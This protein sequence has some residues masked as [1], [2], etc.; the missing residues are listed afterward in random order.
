[1]PIIELERG[2]N[3]IFNW[4]FHNFFIIIQFLASFLSQ[5]KDSARGENLFMLID[6]T[7][8]V[9]VLSLEIKIIILKYTL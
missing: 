2:F 5:T 6:K 4:K 9:G 1:M 8:P 3:Y 7:E